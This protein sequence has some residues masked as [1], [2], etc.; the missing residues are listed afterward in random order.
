[1]ETT[2][3][4]TVDL[5][6]TKNNYIPGISEDFN[7]QIRVEAFN[8]LNRTTFDVPKTSQMS[9]FAGDG[10]LN[11][12]AGKSNRTFTNSREVQLGLKLIF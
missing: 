11:S 7:V 10:T 1:M 12:T 2:G 4:Q 3:Y 5:V 6:L 9:V 8:A